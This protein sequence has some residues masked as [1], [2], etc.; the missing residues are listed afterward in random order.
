[1]LQLPIIPSHK[2]T[3][4]RFGPMASGYNPRSI[5]PIPCPS[6]Q[7][8]EASLHRDINYVNIFFYFYSRSPCQIVT[9]GIASLIF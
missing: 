3:S 2:V 8:R 4:G 7:D 9:T 6:P 5:L 1:M